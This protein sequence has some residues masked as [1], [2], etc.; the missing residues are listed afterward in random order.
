MNEEY[1][2]RVLETYSNLRTTLDSTRK[3]Y[4]G[5]KKMKDT[6]LKTGITYKKDLE[7]EIAYLK[8]Q[9]DHL[10][11]RKELLN[12]LQNRLSAI[13]QVKQEHK[14]NSK[15]E[16][17]VANGDQ[18]YVLSMV[19]RSK[20]M[21]ERY[22]FCKMIGGRIPLKGNVPHECLDIT[23]QEEIEKEEFE[24]QWQVAESHWDEYLKIQHIFETIEENKKSE[25][26]IA[27]PELNT[28][29][30]PKLVVCFDF[31]STNANELSIKSNEKVTLLQIVKGGWSLI[32]NN[33][34]ETGFVPSSFLTQ[35]IPEDEDEDEEEEEHEEIMEQEN[36]EEN[37]HQNENENE[38]ENENNKEKENEE[39]E[40]KFT[41]QQ[42]NTKI[43]KDTEKV[44]ENETEKEKETEKITKDETPKNQQRKE[45]KKVV[46]NEKDFEWYL[47][48][49][50]KLRRHV[51]RLNKKLI[52]IKEENEK[53]KKIAKSKKKK[54]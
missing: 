38:N 14:A 45:E 23:Q 27:I 34:K 28:L 32:S 41:I 8:K 53:L 35:Y 17:S 39:K 9:L 15:K 12:Y 3:Q 24:Q 7:Y 16:L 43:Q 31:D 10:K 52:E 5:M 21:P 42:E 46:K 54:N 18:L 6:Y 47:K 36:E 40:E 49:N 22:A 25:Q 4:L 19:G 13:A 30:C 1:L 29:K 20:E 37:L 33:K 50:T 51:E 26:K 11:K 48:A 44:T 2:K